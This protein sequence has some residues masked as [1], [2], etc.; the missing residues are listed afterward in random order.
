MGGRTRESR[1]YLRRAQVSQIPPGVLKAAAVIAAFVLILALGR[2]LPGMGGERFE[3]AGGDAAAAE[4][5]VEGEGVAA[6]EES[7]GGGASAAVVFVHVVGA[8]NAPGVYELH[9]GDRV[10]AA[11]E[12][13]GG[14]RDDAA[15][16]AVNLARDVVDGEQIYV[17]TNDEA[18]QVATRQ[19][20]VAGAGEASGSGGL[21]NINTATAEELQTLP[22][23]GP[24][25]AAS[26]VEYREG[27]GTF[28]KPEDIKNVS[29]I[30]DGKYEKLADKIC[31]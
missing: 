22:G 4:V 30:G 3:V 5:P 31:V 7:D 21:V 26:I 11:V 23:V 25:T 6:A 15:V 29:G 1:E 17:P 27:G 10:L 18:G 28:A 16:Q 14:L 8:V 20:T 19:A 24:A 2:W 12:A 9:E 13:A